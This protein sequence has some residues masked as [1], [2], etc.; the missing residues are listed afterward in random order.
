[1]GEE[2]SAAAQTVSSDKFRN[3]K[4][5]TTNDVLNG[6]YE[7]SPATYKFS[8][9]DRKDAFKVKIPQPSGSRQMRVSTSAQENCH[10]AKISRKTKTVL[11]VSFFKNFAQPQDMNFETLINRAFEFV[12]D[13]RINEA[14]PFFFNDL[15]GRSYSQRQKVHQQRDVSSDSFGFV[16]NY[17]G[18]TSSTQAVQEKSGNDSARGL[19]RAFS[20]RQKLRHFIDLTSHYQE[21]P[22]HSKKGRGVIPQQMPAGGLVNI[23]ISSEIA[24]PIPPNRT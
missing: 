7:K 3:G 21:P 14:E 19:K 22:Q 5:T 13:G 1:M 8:F 2:Q 6:L 12:V 24:I 4:N 17:M 10:L 9:C 20:Q 15:L 16:N 18:T 11:S 23:A